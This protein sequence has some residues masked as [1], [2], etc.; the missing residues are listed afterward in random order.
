[1]DARHALPA[2]TERTSFG[3]R[4][5]D[6]HSKLLDARIVFLGTPIDE[7]AAN[8]VIAHLLYLDHAAP[9]QDI[10]LYI[11]S[12]G[13]SVTAMTAIHDTMTTL[14]CDVETVCLGQAG[15]TAAVLLAAGTPGKRMTLP[16]ARVTL[17]QPA[18]DEPARGQ[19]D[20]LDLQ[21][22]ELLRLRALMTGLLAGHTGRTREQ[23]EA[24][25]DRLTVLDAQG[26]VAYGLVDAVVANR[27]PPAG[28]A[29]R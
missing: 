22:R 14:Y 5:L 7:T 27:R 18:L 8:D 29:A 6:P 15:S 20:D 24:D 25:L 26:A 4:T 17:R 16:G 10:S 12:P 21:A 23:V 3:T 13:G 28:L 19:I 2:F 11:H 1:M 9:G